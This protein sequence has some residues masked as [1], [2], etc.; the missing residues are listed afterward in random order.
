MTNQAVSVSARTNVA[1]WAAG[2]AIVASKLD[3]GPVARITIVPADRHAGYVVCKPKSE[4][5]AVT[6]EE[7]FNELVYALA[8]L[9]ATDAFRPGERDTGCSSDLERATALAGRISS[10]TG[11][12]VGTLLEDART[13]A[14]SLLE[15]NRDSV[16]AVVQAL[17]SQ[18]TL[19]GE[20][21]AKVVAGVIH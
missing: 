7:L 17:L 21:F 14:Q 18:Q 13:R 10:L 11:E 16:E 20:E 9:A 15:E 1:Y 2:H 4:A 6:R 12:E 3:T 5:F 19:S 8:G